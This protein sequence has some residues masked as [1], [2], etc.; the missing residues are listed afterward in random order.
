LPYLKGKFIDSDK[1]KITS[2]TLNKLGIGR[3]SF[4]PKLDQK[5][6][7]IMYTNGKE[8]E[9]DFTQKIKLKGVLLKITKINS[10][11]LISI[12]TND[13][14][15]SQLKNKKLKLVFHN[16]L[17]LKEINVDFDTE[18]SITK[19]IPIKN[20]TK[21]IHIFTLFDEN[22]N[23][24]AERLFFNYEGLKVIN[25]IVT[26]I[27]RKDSLIRLGLKY[28]EAN[29]IGFNNVS[30]SILPQ[31]TKSYH[32][33]VNIISQTLIQPY[34]R[35]TL[36]NGAHYFTNINEQ[37]KYDLDNL[38]ITQGWSSYDWDSIFNADHAIKHPLEKGISIEANIP[39]QSKESTYL[40]HHI[41]NKGSEFVSIKKEIKSFKLYDYYPQDE[42]NLYISEVGKKGKLWQAS[43]NLNYFPSSVPNLNKQFKPL[44]PHKNYYSEEIFIG[45]S[46]FSTINNSEVLDEIIIKTNLNQKRIQLIKNKSIG[47]V[48]FIDELDKNL[49]L[50]NFLNMKPGISAYDDIRTNRLKAYNTIS[51]G[52]PEFILDGH[53]VSGDQLYS[54][55]L[56]MVDYINVN[57]NMGIRSGGSI[58]IV[59]DP[60]KFSKDKKTIKK[61]E[62]PITFS[63][64]KKFY[65]PKYQSYTSQFYKEYGV[66]DWLPLNKIDK[67]GNLELNI[68]NV[69][70]NNFKVFIEGVT[71]DG[72][73]IF[74]EKTVQIK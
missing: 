45:A 31:Q 61:F 74:E 51:G 13:S 66:I 3:F 15:I 39:K 36:E 24:L 37:K 7:A 32:K 19:T 64:P 54:Y 26:S 30:V 44:N 69:P 34:I 55:W 59:T 6:K 16:G 50:A 28:Q 11:L 9:I 40:V 4:K 73:F 41:S 23:P 47:P 58:N 67:N 65:T 8:I 20:L 43:L 48:Y 53:R 38:L 60:L 49:T 70:L 12:V 52:V 62:F 18:L 46:N 1:N 10:R 29:N 63:K 35:G 71:E 68:T 27:H 17:E 57:S 22:N 42:E 72:T 5:Y 56:T 2:F 21:G 33:N 25:S 14:S